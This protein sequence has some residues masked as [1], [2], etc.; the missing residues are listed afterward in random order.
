MTPAQ[1]TR[2]FRD[3]P[4]E[5]SPHHV[6]DD[7]N[8]DRVYLYLGGTSDICHD[9]HNAVE[10][11]AARIKSNNQLT[12]KQWGELGGLLKR[13][14]AAWR[15]IPRWE[16]KIRALRDVIRDYLDTEAAWRAGGAR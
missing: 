3:W 1:E 4:G 14:H 12:P 2:Q 16:P 9:Y 6:G 11:M 5:S 15:E 7:A 10:Y 13:Y 8:G